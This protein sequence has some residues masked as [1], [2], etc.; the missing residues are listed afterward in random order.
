MKK[1]L[2]FG[3]GNIGRGFFGQLYYESGYHI[4]F[5]DIVEQVINLLNDKNEYPLWLV[6]ENLEK[7]TIKNVSGIKLSDVQSILETSRDIELISFSVGVNNVK[8]LIPI[9][10]K[11][12][13]NK[14]KLKPESNLNIIIGENMKDASKTVRKWIS[15][16]LNPEATDYFEKKV[17]LVETVLS[18][19]I[20]VVPDEIKKQYPLIILAEPYKIMP[21]AKNMFKG[22]LPNIKGFL[23]VENIESYEAMKLYIHNLTHAAFAYA[24]HLKGYT[25]IW[26]SVADEKIRF[27]VDKAYL[28]IKMAIN[29]KYG[30]SL[31]EIDDYYNDLIERFSNKSLADTVKRVARE[32]IRK[33]GPEDR[34][35]GAA[36]LCENHQIKPEYISIIAAFCLNYDEPSDTESQKMKFLLNNQGIDYVLKNISGLAESEPLFQTIKQNYLDFWKFKEKML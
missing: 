23:F 29:K 14:S 25:Y 16:S 27:I 34:I 10:T 30:L 32:P 4:V 9:L 21:V 31:D 22:N 15:E 28:E 7:L 35:I 17:G 12:I 20:P 6:S 33:I 8:G 1:V 3:A 24:G 13:E 26:E 18:R 36:R 2:H 11:I 19:M 5:V